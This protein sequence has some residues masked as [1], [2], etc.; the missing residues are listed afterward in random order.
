VPLRFLLRA[1]RAVPS[2]RFWG[3]F[4]WCWT[5]L[6]HGSTAQFSL[7]AIG[8]VSRFLDT[9]AWV[10]VVLGA[11]LLVLAIVLPDLK[12]W[13]GK[14]SWA[15]TLRLPKTPGERLAILETHVGGY[16]GTDRTFEALNSDVAEHNTRLGAIEAQL[17]DDFRGK[18]LFIADITVLL[19]EAHTCISYFSRIRESHPQT[20]AAKN[21][22][23]KQWWLPEF[24]SD[25]PP[26]VIHWSCIQKDHLG[27]CQTFAELFHLPLS[28]VISQDLQ[29]C[30]KWNSIQTV[31]AC[32]VLLNSQY[33][34]LHALRQARLT[35]PA[36]PAMLPPAT[37][38]DEQYE[39]SHLWTK[40]EN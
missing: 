23:A 26:L 4:V 12:I 19:W 8:S 6:A 21:P 9:H 7:G 36:E 17:S 24:R 33:A 29:D 15:N 13:I 16:L 32:A 5:M 22:F 20:A 31:V 18:L 37:L 35:V 34:K 2:F 40:D 27:H 10:G 39:P 38:L 3:W 14:Q 25:T 1:R 30:L 11:L 28:D